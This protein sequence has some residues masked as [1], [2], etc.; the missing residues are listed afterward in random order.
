MKRQNVLIMAGLC[1]IFLCACSGA[2]DSSDQDSET[3]VQVDREV[4][5]TSIETAMA[6]EVKENIEESDTY[7]CDAD[8]F[9]QGG[10]IVP[11]EQTECTFQITY[12]S[13]NGMGGYDWDFTLENQSATRLT[14]SITAYKTE[15]T[16]V[17]EVRTWCIDAEPGIQTSDIISW[18]QPYTVFHIRIDPEN[19]DAA[20][21]NFIVEY[22]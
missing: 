7:Y 19:G 17:S 4:S 11:L 1:L 22:D 12:I 18:E 16:V 21:E 6:D 20:Y 15:Q 9:S 5:Q 8:F 2:V 14:V 3:L 10:C 13:K